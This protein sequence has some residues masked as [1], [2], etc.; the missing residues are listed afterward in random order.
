MKPTAYYESDFRQ[1]NKRP[2]VEEE[3][4]LTLLNSSDVLLRA[5]LTLVRFGLETTFSNL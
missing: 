2:I 5:Q 1:T 4:P 3:L